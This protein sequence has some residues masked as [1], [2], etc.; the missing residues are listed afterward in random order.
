MFYCDHCKDENDWPG[1][2]ARS[3]G[4]CEVCKRPGELCNDVPSR[5]LPIKEK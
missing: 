2:I 3:L 4:R 1:S 5:L